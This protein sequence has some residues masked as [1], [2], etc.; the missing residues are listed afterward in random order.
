MSGEDLL[1]AAG[2]KT[3]EA[4]KLAAVAKPGR[5]RPLQR[6][7]VR[8]GAIGVVPRVKCSSLCGRAFLF[9]VPRRLRRLSSPTIYLGGA[10]FG[11]QQDP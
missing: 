9:S 3:V 10:D 4:Q 5:V 6:A 11:L 7:R 8:C 2:P 1:G